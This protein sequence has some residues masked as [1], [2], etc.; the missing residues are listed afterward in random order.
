MRILNTAIVLAALLFFLPGIGVA[1]EVV[2]G[3]CLSFEAGQTLTVEEYDTNFA[4]SKYGNPTGVESVFDISQAEIGIVPE[5]DDI[6]RLA[7]ELRQ[8]KKVAF[9]VMNVTRQN[10]MKK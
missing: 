5:K 8:D 1:A 10:L 3:K 9:K 6:V 2:Q 4:T 7:Y